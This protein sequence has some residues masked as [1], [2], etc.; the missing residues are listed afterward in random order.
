VAGKPG[1]RPQADRLLTLLMDGLR[2]RD[3]AGDL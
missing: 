2:N 3:R 1:Q